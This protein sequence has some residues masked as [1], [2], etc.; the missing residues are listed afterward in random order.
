MVQNQTEAIIYILS[1]LTGAFGFI[2]FCLMLQG[3][4]TWL[5]SGGEEFTL[6]NSRKMMLIAG[7][8]IGTS[9][10]VCYFAWSLG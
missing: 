6:R 5:T 8:L 9:L 10:I 4:L 2:G 1:W 7:F 3:F